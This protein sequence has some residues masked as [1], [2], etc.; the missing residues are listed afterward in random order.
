M[1]TGLGTGTTLD[2]EGGFTANLTSI[3]P[4]PESRDSV[5]TSH[6]LTTGAKT[7]I[8]ATLKDCGTIK[9]SGLHDPTLASPCT[10]NIENFTI[11]YPDD[12]TEVGN[13]FCT[14][15]TPGAMTVDGL[16]TFDA[17]FMVTGDIGRYTGSTASPTPT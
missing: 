15:Y 14:G 16:R 17:E 5:D 8:P 10:G 6:L 12:E 2:L 3:T 13:C 7:K 11:T 1:A 4:A 9:I